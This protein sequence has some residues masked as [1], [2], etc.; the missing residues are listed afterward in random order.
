MDHSNNHED[1]SSDRQM[2]EH[3]AVQQSLLDRT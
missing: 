1:V 3:R 2:N